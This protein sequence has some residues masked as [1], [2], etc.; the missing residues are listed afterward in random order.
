MIKVIIFDWG[1]V[2]CFFDVKGFNK[3]ISAH[4]KVDESL[5]QKV[6]LKNRL[7]HDLGEITTKQFV[8]NICNG[9]SRK[10]SVDDYYSLATRFKHKKL[11]E[12]IIPIIKQLKKK[13]KIFLLS[14]SNKRMFEELMKSDI[15]FLFDKILISFQ[16]GIKKPDKMF[17]DLLLKGTNYSF[18]DCLIVDDREDVCIAAKSY[19]MSSITFRNN[20]Q[21]KKEFSLHKIIID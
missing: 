6:E 17:F 18:K 5:F 19:G 21:L 2:I 3:K 4:L 20:E 1:N 11:N 10:M 8:E 14:N 13:Y 12:Q 7:K 9:I 15:R 16:V